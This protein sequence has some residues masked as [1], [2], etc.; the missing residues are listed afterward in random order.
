M[1]D[2]S[3][4]NLENLKAALKGATA[5]T[6][7]ILCLVVVGFIEALNVLDAERVMQDVVFYL[8]FL[9]VVFILLFVYFLVLSLKKD[10]PFW[11]AFLVQF[12]FIVPLSVL[13]FWAI[14][15]NGIYVTALVYGMGA[16]LFF[17][18]AAAV[19]AWVWSKPSKM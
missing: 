19:G 12:I 5:S 7:V 4:S 3:N 9:F 17:G 13:I 16:F 8:G 15:Q 11:L 18:F 6:S 2:K 14:S 10:R 1:S